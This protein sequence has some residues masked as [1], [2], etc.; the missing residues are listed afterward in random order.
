M[1]T[2]DNPPS[3]YLIAIARRKLLL[4]SAAHDFPAI[5]RAMNAFTCFGPH[6]KGQIAAVDGSR[7][8]VARARG[9][10]FGRNVDHEGAAAGS[11]CSG[12]GTAYYWDTTASESA[13]DLRSR[14]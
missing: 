13:I 3:S 6:V 2:A 10:K 1:K 4:R 12:S 8:A 7:N 11:S 5:R 14:S 9:H